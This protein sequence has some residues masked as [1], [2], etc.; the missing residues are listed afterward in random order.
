MTEERC[1]KLKEAGKC[2]SSCTKLF[3]EEYCNK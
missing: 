3:R 1:K 2:K